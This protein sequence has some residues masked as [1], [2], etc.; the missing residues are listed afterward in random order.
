MLIKGGSGGSPQ[1]M[2]GYTKY[3]V[4]TSCSDRVN[5]TIEPARLVLVRIR[6][7]IAYRTTI[8]ARRCQG[9]FECM[10]HRQ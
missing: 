6:E 7:D 4:C 3:V 1:S 2:I 9:Y 10:E 8:H 5:T